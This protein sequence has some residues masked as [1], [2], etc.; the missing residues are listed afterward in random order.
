MIADLQASPQKPPAASFASPSDRVW[1][2]FRSDPVGMAAALVV[3]LFF[4]TAL[5]VGLCAWF[6]IYFPHDPNATHLAL[7]LKGPSLAHWLGTD[8]LGRDVFSRM[9][10]GSYISLTV[11][12]IAVAVSLLIGVTIGAISG[13][14]GGW[15][16][17]VIMRVVD[18]ILCFPTFFLILTAVALLGPNILNIIVIIG[19]VSWTGT[20][21]L[22][23]AEFLTLRESEY[24]RAARTLGQRST[25]IIFR[26]ILPNA[27]API[28]VTAVL[29][30]PEA[31]L[32]EASLSFL[33]FGVQPPQATWGNIITDGKTYLLDAWWLIVFPG[34]A[35]F[36]ATLSFYLAGDALRQASETR[37]EKK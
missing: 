5:V 20:A 16:D 27:A 28:I 37:S 22:V 12:F 24:V 29:G 23:R 2:R 7:K 26:H 9:L 1:A 14:L 21:R 19:L 32:T 18:A 31:I 4:A 8:N 30:I 17:N 15:V 13:Y 11:G 35:I 25:L 10:T 36:I 3:A 33:G 34:L 6:G